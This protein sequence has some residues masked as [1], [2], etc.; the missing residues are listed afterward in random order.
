VRLP[1]SGDQGAQPNSLRLASVNW[2]DTSRRSH[3]ALLRTPP[4]SHDPRRQP[5]RRG[6]AGSTIPPDGKPE[7][8]KGR[9]FVGWSQPIPGR[10]QKA[11]Q[12]F[13]EV[14]QVYGRLQQQGDHALRIVVRTNG[15]DGSVSRSV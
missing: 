9:L 1:G 2:R 8:G 10:E 7:H 15:D 14:I 6:R 11:V 3:V 5:R 13:Q 12:L 4:W